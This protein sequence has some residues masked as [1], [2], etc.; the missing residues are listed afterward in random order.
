MEG[1]SAGHG[2]NALETGLVFLAL[3]GGGVIAV[4]LYIFYYNPDYTKQMKAIAPRPVPPEIRLKPLLIAAP[5]MVIS[6]F[7]CG[8]TSY[9]SISIAS[10]ILAILLLGFCVL[11]IFLACFNVS[12]LPHSYA[13]T[14]SG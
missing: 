3:L 7:W 5:A 4:L 11:F 6:F 1:H 12:G 8:W 9:D 10:P 13:R 2:L 14:E